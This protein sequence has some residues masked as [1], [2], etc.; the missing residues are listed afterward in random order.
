MRKSKQE[1]LDERRVNAA[2]SFGLLNLAINVMDI[3]KVFAEAKR[4][5]A[6]G[7]D[8]NAMRVGVRAFTQT[9]VKE[10]A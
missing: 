2:V 9:L 1:K 3:S 6:A 7:A 5:L 8:D 10:N 4:L